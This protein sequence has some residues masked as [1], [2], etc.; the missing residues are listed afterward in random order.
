MYWAHLTL[1]LNI[2]LFLIS[3]IFIPLFCLPIFEALNLGLG[4]LLGLIL[5]FSFKLGPYIFPFLELGNPFL[6]SLFLILDS[7]ESLQF[8]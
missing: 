5:P 4:P 3:K 6:D 7:N 2:I 8:L 1:E